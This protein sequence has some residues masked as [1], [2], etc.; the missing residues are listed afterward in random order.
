M[1]DLLLAGIVPGLLCM[2]ALTAIMV[3]LAELKEMPTTRDVGFIGVGLRHH[4]LV[5][6]VEEGG[7]QHAEPGVRQIMGIDCYI[8]STPE[9]LSTCSTLVPSSPPE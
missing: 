2:Q 9:T 3:L 1:L 8:D 4:L 5:V 6:L 7:G